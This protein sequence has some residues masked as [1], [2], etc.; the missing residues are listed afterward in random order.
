MII[1]DVVT[2]VSLSGKTNSTVL[3]RGSLISAMEYFSITHGRLENV[4]IREIPVPIIWR[5][6]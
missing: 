4:T 6:R 3:T 5:T 1:L 2:R